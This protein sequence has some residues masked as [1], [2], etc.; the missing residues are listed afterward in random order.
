MIKNEDLENLAKRV[1]AEFNL[2]FFYQSDDPEDQEMMLENLKRSEAM[3][4]FAIGRFM[5]YFNQL[6][7]ENKTVNIV[8]TEDNRVENND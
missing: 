6:A 5:E 4:V 1:A 2:E 8:L 3:T 7:E